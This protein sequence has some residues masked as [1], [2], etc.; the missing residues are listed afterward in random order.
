LN[1]DIVVAMR[2]DDVHVNIQDA[3]GDRVL[4]GELLKKDQTQWHTW[5]SGKRGR[6]KKSFNNKQEELEEV[7]YFGAGED[8]DVHHY[9]GAAKKKKKFP[10]TP[11]LRGEPD[12]CRIWGS[13]EGNKVQGDFHIT[14]RGHGYMELGMHLDHDSMF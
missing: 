8:E 7:S 4:A 6:G 2:C 12:S 5:L 1:L 13:L 11:R 3:A 9:L 10:K 14:A